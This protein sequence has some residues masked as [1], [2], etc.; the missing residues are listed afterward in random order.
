VS[1]N[2]RYVPIDPHAIAITGALA[3]AHWLRLLSLVHALK[4]LARGVRS[5][6]YASCF[7]SIE[8]RVPLTFDEVDC[9]DYSYVVYWLGLFLNLLT[10]YY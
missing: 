10:K 9:Q 3:P 7:L 4:H 5:R 2:L 8:S 1:L 6:Y